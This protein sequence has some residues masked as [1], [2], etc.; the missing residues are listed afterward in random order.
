MILYAPII[1]PSIPAFSL[2]TTT[3]DEQEY[4]IGLKIGFQHN[5]AVAETDVGGI[6]CLIKDVNTGKIISKD[7]FAISIDWN[8]S[9]CTANIVFLPDQKPEDLI[10]GNFYKIQ[11]AYVDKAHPSTIGPYSTVG[12]TRYLGA[13][14]RF[15]LG[16]NDLKLK[17]TNKNRIKYKW[18]KLRCLIK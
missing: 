4:Y 10:L 2:T 9:T 18:T 7:G 5:I 15:E 17:E 13:S 12:I 3:I 8:T 14:G 11:I 1:E 6:V 16:I